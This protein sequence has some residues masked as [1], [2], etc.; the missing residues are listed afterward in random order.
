MDK[1]VW[2]WA[3]MMEPWFSNQQKA[4]LLISLTAFIFIFSQCCLIHR[5]LNKRR[6]CP[7]VAFQ[8]LTL[9]EINILFAH[10]LMLWRTTPYVIFIK[11][12]TWFFV[13]FVVL[14]CVVICFFFC[15]FFALCCVF[16]FCHL[17]SK[18]AAC[19]MLRHPSLGSPVLVRWNM[20]I[21]F[22]LIH[23]RKSKDPPLI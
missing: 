16:I 14:F 21:T 20:A 23:H 13:I 11:R 1:E 3:W 2:E 19:L 15:F 6:K 17:A 22:V 5:N 12:Q 8:R 9:V 10:T 7:L 4:F 18:P